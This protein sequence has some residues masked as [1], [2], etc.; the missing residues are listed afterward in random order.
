MTVGRTPPAP[1]SFE[2]KDIVQDRIREERA[3]D[4]AGF[5]VEPGTH[6]VARSQRRVLLRDQHEQLA[7]GLERIAELELSGVL[8]DD[9]NDGGAHRGTIPGHE[10]SGWGLT[11]RHCVPI[12]SD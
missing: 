2:E 5:V 1:L 8:D 6:P 12:Y 9:G 11:S 7:L 3:R 10:I 4:V